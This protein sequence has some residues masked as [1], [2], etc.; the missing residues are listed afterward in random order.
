MKRLYISNVSIS[1]GNIKYPIRKSIFG[2][3]N[4]S[5]K[6][7]LA[8]VAYADIRSLNSPHTFFKEY[9][10]NMLVKFERNRMV[11][12]TPNF[13]LFYKKPYTHSYWNQGACKNPD[14]G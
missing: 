2:V 13:E 9:L 10:Y 1:N 5:L 11:Q 8:T 14:A 3:N 7:F 6:R 12:T 4:L